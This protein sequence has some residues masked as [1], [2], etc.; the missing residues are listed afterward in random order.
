MLK[1]PNPLHSFFLKL[2]QQ[3]CEALLLVATPGF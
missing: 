3:W 1:G 2:K